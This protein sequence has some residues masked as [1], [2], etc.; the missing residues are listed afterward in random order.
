MLIVCYG[1][2]D[3]NNILDLSLNGTIVQ[4]NCLVMGGDCDDPSTVEIDIK[5]PTRNGANNFQICLQECEQAL[6]LMQ[7]EIVLK[8]CLAV[9]NEKFD[10]AELK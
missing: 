5:G 2:E 1:E 3:S 8:N 9:P 7:F 6:C 10:D 4:T